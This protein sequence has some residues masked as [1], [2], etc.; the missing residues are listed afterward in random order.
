MCAQI[1]AFVPSFSHLFLCLFFLLFLTFLGTL[2]LRL[3]FF[4]FSLY[5]LLIHVILIIIAILLLTIIDFLQHRGL[6]CHMHLWNW[7]NINILII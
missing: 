5:L 4:H 6:L 7:L 1:G 3:D 2:E